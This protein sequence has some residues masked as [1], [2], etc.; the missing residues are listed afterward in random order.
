[1]HQSGFASPIACREFAAGWE[2]SFTR[3]AEILAEESAMAKR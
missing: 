1:L 3:L 2:T